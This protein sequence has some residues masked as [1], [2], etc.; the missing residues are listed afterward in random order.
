LQEKRK[1]KGKVQKN[2][3]LRGVLFRLAIDGVQRT[4][5]NIQAQRAC[6][7]RM[8]VRATW[9]LGEKK[10]GSRQGSSLLGLDQMVMHGIV[11]SRS[12]T[13]KS[14]VKAYCWKTTFHHRKRAT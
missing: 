12:T 1:K 7:G 2:Y 9:Y 3:L 4:V 10:K 13:P 8:N 5:G 14:V 6:K 11:S